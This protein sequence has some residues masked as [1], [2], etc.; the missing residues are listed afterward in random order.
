MDSASIE[1][2]LLHSGDE[3]QWTVS[4]DIKTRK[5]DIWETWS[6]ANPGLFFYSK[7]FNIWEKVF[8]KDWLVLQYGWK[9][10]K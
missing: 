1:N 10:S 4:N 9:I 5:T 7:S 8:W 2:A 6:W 3:D